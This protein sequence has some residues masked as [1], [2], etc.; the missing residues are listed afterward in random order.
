MSK[1]IRIDADSYI[2]A[3]IEN[4]ELFHSFE[5]AVAIGTPL[6][7]LPDITVIVQR[8]P[9]DIFKVGCW[10]FISKKLAGIFIDLG[11]CDE[12]IQ[13]FKA[14]V[15]KK[16]GKEFGEYVFLHVIKKVNCLDTSKTISLMRKGFYM[17]VTKLE[18]LEERVASSDFIFRIEKLAMAVVVLNSETVKKL[19]MSNL[20]GLRY[21]TFGEFNNSVY[22]NR[23]T[24]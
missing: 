9:D 7:Y 8:K 17:D 20:R 11:A 10:T 1:I 2:S 4:Y 18:I 21:F 22:V 5:G 12:C 19:E 15:K 3:E 14:S 6:D 13:I 16:N 23:H 24:T